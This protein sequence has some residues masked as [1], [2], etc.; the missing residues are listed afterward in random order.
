MSERTLFG[1]PATSDSDP[2]FVRVSEFGVPRGNHQTADQ[3][4]PCRTNCQRY[5]E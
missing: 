4:D 1:R 5:S 2:P 3:P